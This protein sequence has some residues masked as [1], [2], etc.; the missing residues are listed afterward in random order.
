M[1]NSRYPSQEGSTASL[2]TAV[3]PNWKGEGM[4][5]FGFEALPFSW[6]ALFYLP[7]F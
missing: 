3:F 4:L 1:V 5:V 6:E 2:K 7:S